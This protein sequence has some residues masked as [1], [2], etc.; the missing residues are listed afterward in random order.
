MNFS[1]TFKLGKVYS[2]TPP[3]LS[4]QHVRDKWVHWIYFFRCFSH[5][6]SKDNVRHIPASAAFCGDKLERHLM[7]FALPT[8]MS[9]EMKVET[10][11]T[12]G[13]LRDTENVILS[14]FLKTYTFV[15]VYVSVYICVCMHIY[16][17]VCVCV[18]VSMCV[19]VFVCV[20][21][22]IFIYVCVGNIY[23][24]IYMCV[25]IYIYMCVCVCVCGCV[26]KN[27][28]SSS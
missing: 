25:Y 27:F 16:M 2:Q 22:Y 14:K 17:C 12:I 21:M 1:K 13:E 28:Y 7:I 6:V 26:H 5:I 9:L 19:Y 10:V 24:Y 15:Q 4:R 3:P 11:D 8:I 18:C 23:G 20:Y